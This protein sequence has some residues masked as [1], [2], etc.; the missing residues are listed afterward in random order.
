MLSVVKTRQ[1]IMKYNY[2]LPLFL[3]LSTSFRVCTVAVSSMQQV[4]CH[5]CLWTAGSAQGVGVDGELKTVNEILDKVCRSPYDLYGLGL[6]K[7]GPTD[8]L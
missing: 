6:G 7:S 5:W 4:L 8:W 1:Y 3:Q 2:F